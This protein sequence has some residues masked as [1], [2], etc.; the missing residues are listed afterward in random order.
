MIIDD[1]GDEEKNSCL[2]DSNMLLKFIWKSYTFTC[3]KYNS[4][5]EI[6]TPI[7]GYWRDTID[8]RQVLSML[9]LVF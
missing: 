3:Q 1:R 4:H 6:F 8:Y 9:I 2:S 7:P 5:S